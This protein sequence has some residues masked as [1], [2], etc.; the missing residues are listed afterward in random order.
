MVLCV[1]TA[2]VTAPAPPDPASPVATRLTALLVGTLVNVDGC[3][4]V[5]DHESGTSYLLVWLP[6]QHTV[7]AEGNT[8]HIVDHLR[9]DRTVVW[10][11]GQ[12]VRLGGGVAAGESLDEPVRRS[13]PAHCPGPYWVVGDVGF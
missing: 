11:T 5:T 8:L 4:R 13:L 7:T 9:G 1:V 6:E 12:T 10:Y 2:C 3:L